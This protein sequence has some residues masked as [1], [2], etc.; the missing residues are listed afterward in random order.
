[1]TRVVK[2]LVWRCMFQPGMEH[3]ALRETEGGWQL[4]GTVVA[5]VD[6]QPLRV[7]YTIDCSTS[8][9]TR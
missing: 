9:H 5:V 1:M 6:E 4:A 8:W 7:A 3:F 2:S